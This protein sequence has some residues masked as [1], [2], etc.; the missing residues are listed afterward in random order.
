MPLRRCED[1]IDGYGKLYINTDINVPFAAA[2][3]P[4][5]ERTRLVFKIGTPAL[6]RMWMQLSLNHRVNSK[7]E[8]VNRYV[9]ENVV[10]PS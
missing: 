3:C 10:L 7:A 2:M 8:P 6:R 1:A 9:D 5:S 4:G